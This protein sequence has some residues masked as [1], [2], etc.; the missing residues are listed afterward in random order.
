MENIDLVRKHYYSL[1]KDRRL[2][3]KEYR[4]RLRII[5]LAAHRIRMK[6]IN[7]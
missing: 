3:L 5:S 2:T 4:S 1:F 7:P 6:K